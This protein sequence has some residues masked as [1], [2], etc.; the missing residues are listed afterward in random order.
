MS[1]SLKIGFFVIGLVTVVFNAQVVDAQSQSSTKSVSSVNR[2]PD[3]K[4]TC[5]RFVQEFY[6]YYVPLVGGEGPTAEKAI[7]EKKALFGQDLYKKLKEDFDA[8]A[9]VTG[10]IVGLDFDPFLNSQD[11]APRYVVGEVTER[12]GHYSAAVHSVSSDGKRNPKPDVVPELV[13]K[14]NKWIFLNFHYGKSSFPENENLL[15]VLKALSDSR[16]K[17]PAP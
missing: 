4:K 9:K 14:N 17:N 2:P 10:E 1:A 6:N 11:P 7:E 16:K 13:Q 15:S 12:A 5:K 8:Q 3:K